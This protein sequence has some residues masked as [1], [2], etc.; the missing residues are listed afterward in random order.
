MI[1]TPKVMPTA[2][3]LEL[4]EKWQHAAPVW[5]DYTEDE[6]QATIDALAHALAEA[7]TAGWET[8]RVVTDGS[9][10]RIEPETGV[11]VGWFLS[12]DLAER[13]RV[14]GGETDLH[15]TAVFLGDMADL[16]T[17]QTRLLT[18]IVAE[19]ASAHPA[20]FGVIEGT[21]TFENDDATVWF[22]VPHIEGLESFREKLVVA[23]KGAGF[24]V[25]GKGAD[26][27]HPHITLGF[28]DPGEEPPAVLVP[29]SE[30]FMVRTIT[31][32]VGGTRF[33]VEFADN[34]DAY[35]EYLDAEYKANPDLW[36]KS[37][38]M[39]FVKSV[40]EVPKRF[41]LGPW[42]IPNEVDAHGDWT[43]PDELQQA[44]WSY[45]R[46]GYRGIHLQHSPEIEAGE[47]V[48]AMTL[49]WPMTVPVIDVN[50]VVTAHEY[51]AGTVLLGVVWQPWAWTLVL[52]GKITGYSIGGSSLLRDEPAPQLE[53]SMA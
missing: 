39:P 41:T 17:E 24:E 10:I 1:V 9:D 4:V 7:V 47:W 21:G 6:T 52:E 18:G 5:V 30:P 42:Y 19:V 51:P 48:E 16:T 38:Y 50:G 26:D 28:L 36:R 3:A 46:S 44:L 20:P 12:D 15:V 14:D 53:P 34:H 33:D 37:P 45:V 40:I 29:R 25:Q 2:K 32:A 11:M 13:Y 27:W 49:P 31:V 22:A 8:V 35:G 23:L 43:D